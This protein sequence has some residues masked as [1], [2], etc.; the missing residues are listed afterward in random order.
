MQ[1]SY[2]EGVASHPGPESCAGGREAS[3]EAL[4]GVH[5]GRLLSREINQIRVPTS[6]D[7]AE[8]NTTVRD[9][10]SSRLTRRGRR[11]LACVEAPCTEPG[12]SRD[13]PSRMAA[14]TAQRRRKS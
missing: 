8:G 3:G 12:R 13:R 5:A 1:E 2:R 10:A 14:G 4:T 11:T 6:L 9:S 7:G